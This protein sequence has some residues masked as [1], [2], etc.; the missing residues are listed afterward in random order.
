LLWLLAQ[1]APAPAGQG[2]ATAAPAAAPPP[3]A[4]PAVPAAPPAPPP[5]PPPQ[6]AYAGPPPRAALPPSMQ[7]P[8][9]L[10]LTYVHVLREDGPLATPGMSTNA[11]GI[12]MAFPSNT[13]VRNHL[14]LAHQWES[15]GGVS[16]RGFR[17]D[18][19][20]LGYPIPLVSSRDASFRL[21]LEPILTVV[22]GELMFVDGGGRLLR[23][24]SGFSLEVSATVRHWFV[25]LQA[26][27]ID[28]RYWIYSSDGSFTGFTR[29]IPLRVAI[30]HEF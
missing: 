24:E 8:F 28:F 22:R 14:G 7:T 18:L 5:P 26:F 23:V 30:G 21:D 29:V 20:S 17:I 13:Y 9:R 12:D 25:T 16:A 6:Q 15:A 10:S 11:A 4:A 27:G 2:P 19:V 1:A 3:A